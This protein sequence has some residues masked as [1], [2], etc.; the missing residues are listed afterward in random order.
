MNDW[1]WNLKPWFT[2]LLEY[3]TV[4]HSSWSIV[5]QNAR[6]SSIL[7]E[8]GLSWWLL[9]V[10]FSWSYFWKVGCLPRPGALLRRCIAWLGLQGRGGRL[11]WPCFWCDWSLGRGRWGRWTLWTSANLS[12]K[13]NCGLESILAE[14]VAT[15][16]SICLANWTSDAVVC[17]SPSSSN[18]WCC[19][20]AST[21]SAIDWD[22]SSSLAWSQRQSWYNYDSHSKTKAAGNWS[23][24]WPN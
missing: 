23:Q 18:T 13:S 14:T 10:L 24:L 1:W 19:F 4:C 11:A 9:F 17:Y 20:E 2:I 3:C 16:S 5:S 15:G 12:C 7:R 6:C 8:L 21:H 22:L